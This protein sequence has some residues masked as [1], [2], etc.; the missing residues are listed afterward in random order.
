MTLPI[1]Q[2][3]SIESQEKAARQAQKK[4][5]AAKRENV[6][7]YLFLLP[8]LLG[9]FLLTI[10]PILA[11]LYLSFTRFDLLSAPQWIGLQNY[12]T[13]P[14]D[15]RF[16]TAL[17]VTFSYVF[18]SVPLKLVFALLLALVLNKGVRG[19]AIYRAIFYI[20]SLLGG[21]VAIA[22]LWRQMFGPGSIAEQLASLFGV[23]HA[24]TWILH[25]RQALLTLVALALW[26]FGSPMIIFL[27]GL[28]QIP[29]EL[30]EAAAVD[31]AGPLRTFFHITMPMLTPLIFFNMILQMIAAFQ[32]FT[33]AFILSGGTG[34][35]LD[36]SLFYT[37]YIYLEGFGNFRM[38][39]A[40]AM[41]WI[42]LLLIALFTGIAFLTSRHW[43]FYQD[44]Q[45]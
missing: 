4:S 9:L 6:S 16:L 32:A 26:Q 20:P 42:L 24:G 34:G 18:L 1:S 27:A 15:P 33:P 36:S 13:L 39:Y 44:E 21:S 3:K 8:W 35:V 11:S 28:R 23:Q 10:G 12:L 25:P 43:V 2:Q 14:G 40:S 29:R 19:L 5:A 30:Y 22:I 31:G 37:L 7:G 45:H 38:G 17:Q 41:A